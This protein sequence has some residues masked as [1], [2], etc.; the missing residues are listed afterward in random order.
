L[1][2]Y[3]ASSAVSPNACPALRA[4]TLA[5]AIPGFLANFFSSQATV[6]S[7]GRPYI[8]EMTPRANMFLHRSASFLLRSDALTASI[9]ILVMGILMSW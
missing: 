5:C 6:G 3:A 7:S 8:H 2:S 9:V 1:T 4:A